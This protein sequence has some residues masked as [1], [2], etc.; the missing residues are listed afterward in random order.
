MVERQGGA[1]EEAATDSGED[2][3]EGGTGSVKSNEED[4]ESK[5]SDD[6]EDKK[7]KEVRYRLRVYMKPPQKSPLHQKDQVERHKGLV[8]AYAPTF[9][10]SLMVSASSPLRASLTDIRVRQNIGRR[11]E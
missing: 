11:W 8:G 1:G 9:G 10:D 7:Q 2:R 4:T 5:Q 3:E 6:E